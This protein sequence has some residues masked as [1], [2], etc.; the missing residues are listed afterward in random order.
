M[1][2]PSRAAALPASRSLAAG[3]L[4]RPAGPA[5]ACSNDAEAGPV[6]EPQLAAEAAADGDKAIVPTAAR[7]AMAVSLTASLLVSSATPSFAEMAPAASAAGK[8]AVTVVAAAS[9]SGPKMEAAPVRLAAASSRLLRLAYYAKAAPH[10]MRS[11]YFT[12]PF[13]RC[14]TTASSLR[15]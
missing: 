15:T 12:N 5:A 4:R 13:Y 6:A 14:S 1:G 2:R 11:R 10:C 7:K 8:P 3:L 9:S